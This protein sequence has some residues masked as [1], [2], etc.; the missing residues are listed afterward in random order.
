MICFLSG[1]QKLSLSC[2]KICIKSF[3]WDKTVCYTTIHL[4]KSRVKQCKG[5]STSGETGKLVLTF[6]YLYCWQTKHLKLI[7]LVTV[8]DSL[9]HQELQTWQNALHIWSELDN[10]R[11]TW[12]FFKME[13]SDQ[14]STSNKNYSWND[15]INSN[16]NLILFL[17]KL[18]KQNIIKKAIENF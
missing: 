9:I 7:L 13:P 10:L 5:S 2:L 4:S 6:Q 17:R 3:W 8:I 16:N 14:S 18:I 12:Y 1:F 15:N 11:K